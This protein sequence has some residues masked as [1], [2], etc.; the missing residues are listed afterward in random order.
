[1]F[2]NAAV[3]NYRRRFMFLLMLVRELKD[4]DKQSSASRV[5]Q[6]NEI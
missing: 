5:E 6:G 2:F 1:M 3:I 4:G